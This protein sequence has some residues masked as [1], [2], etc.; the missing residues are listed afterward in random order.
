MPRREWDEGFSSI[1]IPETEF[2]IERL[3]AA[4][5]RSRAAGARAADRNEFASFL[6]RVIAQ[7]IRHIKWRVALDRAGVDPEEAATDL[8]SR[9]EQKCR[10]FNLTHP[11]PRCLVASLNTAVARELI[12]LLRDRR[13]RE[14]F[15]PRSI[16]QK[17]DGESARQYA[18]AREPAP[19]LS[20]FH[21]SLIEEGERFTGGNSELLEL[22]RTM[23]GA[24]ASGRGTPRF[25]SLPHKLQHRIGA[26]A[27]FVLLLNFNTSIEVAIANSIRVEA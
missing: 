3:F 7:N 6:A 23:A 22:W 2:S 27:Y 21:R 5:V 12:T 13:S 24:V 11:A 18:D 4:F 15:R 1:A 17:V 19:D 8:L 20:A 9:I 10:R 16:D 25:S 26:D 14:R